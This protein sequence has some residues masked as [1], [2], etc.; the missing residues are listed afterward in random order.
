MDITNACR[1]S[2]FGQAGFECNDGTFILAIWESAFGGIP[3]MASAATYM[4]LIPRHLRPGR[5]KEYLAFE[6]A[7]KIV[8][9]R[10]KP[11]APK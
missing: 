9:Q 10:W 2:R 3:I 1:K 11:I 8:G 6:E 7:N 5:R 4:C